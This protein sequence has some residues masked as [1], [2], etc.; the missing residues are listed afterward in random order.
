MTL[1]SLVREIIGIVL[2]RAR[3]RAVPHEPAISPAPS[4][5]TAPTWRRI[6]VCS[7]RLSLRMHIVL[8]PTIMVDVGPVVAPLDSVEV[9]HH[10]A[11]RRLDELAPALLTPT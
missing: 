5:T 7:T 10:R 1:P 9:R 4:K 3:N 8:L 2:V 11:R 6:G